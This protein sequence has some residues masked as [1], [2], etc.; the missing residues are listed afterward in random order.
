MNGAAWDG[1][2]PSV[3]VAL[4]ASCVL[5]G[6]VL[7][8]D[9]FGVPSGQGLITLRGSLDGSF[10]V[11]EEGAVWREHNIHPEHDGK[12]R[13]TGLP[14]RQYEFHLTWYPQPGESWFMS[15]TPDQDAVL[16]S[17]ASS[18]AGMPNASRPREY[19][20]IFTLEPGQTLTVS[21]PRDDL[22]RNPERQAALEAA[23]PADAELHRRLLG[24]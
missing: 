4:E 11:Q 24:V 22:G 15:N 6:E 23:S 1:R 16:V 21:Y 9:G 13:I 12:F 14:A 2:T 17:Q 20:D 18:G 3:T 10:D 19:T 7:G 8:E 5:E